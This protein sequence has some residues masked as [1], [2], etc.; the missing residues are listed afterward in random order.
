MI[1]AL[2]QRLPVRR[3]AAQRDTPASVSSPNSSDSSSRANVD[4]LLMS[5]C[6]PVRRAA[7]RA[8][9]PSRPIDSDSWSSGTMTVACRFS[10]STS[11]SRTRAGESAFAT[12]RAGSS[13]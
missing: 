5:M 1:A 7:S 9:M 6:H 11:T 3:I 10:S 12:Y 13:L 2:G 4:S 8:F